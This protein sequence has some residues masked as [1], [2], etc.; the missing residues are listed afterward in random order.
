MTNFYL[1]NMLP[2][3]TSSGEKIISKRDLIWVI[4]LAFIGLTMNKLPYSNTLSILL[5]SGLIVTIYFFNI[6]RPV[7]VIISY[8]F[9]N[10]MPSRLVGG[11]SENVASYFTLNTK[12]FIVLAILLW[13]SSY[14]YKET[15]NIR[16]Y[17]L[18][19]VCFSLFAALT[20]V[21]T[22]SSQYYYQLW[23]ICVA[24]VLFPYFINTE[25]DLK[26]IL[27][28]YFTYVQIF[29]ISIF[30]KIA[31]KNLYRGIIVLDPNFASFTIIISVVSALI[32]LTRYKNELSKVFKMGLIAGMLFDVAMMSF[33]ASRTAFLC[34]AILLIVFMFINIAKIKTIVFTL[35][36][37]VSSYIA[38]DNYGYFDSVFI[39]FSASS[40]N[41]PGGRIGIW[42]DLLF[43]FGELNF[44]R[45]FFGN[46]FLTA[47]MMGTGMQAHNTYLSI[48]VGFGIIGLF[49]FLGYQL[50]TLINIFINGFAPYFLFVAC[51]LIYNFSL[52]PY[53]L[54]EGVVIFSLIGALNSNIP[55]TMFESHGEK[56]I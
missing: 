30:P 26:L 10:I 49:F 35:I 23:W 3:D 39:R 42:Q 27:F 12:N 44:F 19:L 13:I 28:S 9:L 17:N 38:L 5:Q 29:C 33:F 52:E 6:R 47:G 53:L 32:I 48:L 50:N 56:I 36:I 1:N 2:H 14:V 43:S 34:L 24:Y 31:T 22:A 45:L 41:N 15:G 54:P 51:L 18:W 7:I 55:K 11:F 16:K 4:M 46:G 40:L 21:W 37:T 20:F 8:I 25:D